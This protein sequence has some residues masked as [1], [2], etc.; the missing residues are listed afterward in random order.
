MNKITFMQ[1]FFFLR[2]KNFFIMSDNLF[3]FQQDW[4]FFCFHKMVLILFLICFWKSFFFFEKVSVLSCSFGKLLKHGTN[5]KILLKTLKTTSPCAFFFQSWES[6]ISRWNFFKSFVCFLE[7]EKMPLNLIEI[8]EQN[9][10]LHFKK[11]TW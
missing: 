7:S 3:C 11:E 8:W 4:T 6:D 2:Q 1:P 9:I 5:K 10:V